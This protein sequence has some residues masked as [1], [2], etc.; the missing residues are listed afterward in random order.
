MIK[1]LLPVLF[2]LV[3]I[4]SAQAQYKPMMFGMRIGTDLGWVKPDAD[5]YSGDGVV[6]GFT[7]GFISEFF[8]MENYAI[9]TGFTVDFNGGKLQ[10]P[11]LMDVLVGD[12][13]ETVSGQM[14]RKYNLK[15]IEIPLC[16]KM[17]TDLTEKL[18]IF[19]KIGLGTS[20]RLSAKA[21]DTFVYDGGELD[22]SKHNIDSEVAL[23]RESLIVGGGVELKIK[24]ST[25]V[26]LEITYDNAFN[27]MLTGNNP[28]VPDVKPKAIHNFVE[29]G[30]GIVF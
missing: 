15:Y 25:A 26:I 18:A 29:L 6:A 14:H 20:F 11:A 4:S 1:K 3:L 2:F 7:W 24:G 19:G 12:T 10:Y 17:K 8:I 21:T 9:L 5:G 16:L 13:Y 23:L 28:A 22:K 30:A 27:N